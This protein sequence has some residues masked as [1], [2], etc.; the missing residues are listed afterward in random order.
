M[1]DASGMQ[2]KD[3]VGEVGGQAKLGLELGLKVGTDEEISEGAQVVERILGEVL[4][5]DWVEGFGKLV[6][7]AEAGVVHV[8]K[9]A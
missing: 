5:G 4:K 8:L 3:G 7:Q 2:I 1:R 6:D 9:I